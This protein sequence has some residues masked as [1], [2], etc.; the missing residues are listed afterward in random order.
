MPQIISLKLRLIRICKDMPYILEYS[1]NAGIS[2]NIRFPGSAETGGFLDI[3]R[4]GETIYA[5]TTSGKFRSVDGGE[6][7][8]RVG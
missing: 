6:N 7:W 8:M 4:V 2:W 1:D 3:F 5:T